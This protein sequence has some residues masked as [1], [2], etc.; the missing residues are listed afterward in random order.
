MLK[1][2]NVTKKY[3]KTTALDDVSMELSEGECVLLL[4]ANGAGKTT[5]LQWIMGNI[6]AESGRFDWSDGTQQVGYV[7]QDASLM[8][9]VTI[10]EL[11][12]FT[13]KMYPDPLSY[14]EVLQLS[15]LTE[16][17]KVKTDHLSIGQKRKLIFALALVGR[18]KLLIMDE[19]TAGMDVSARKHVYE[20][21]RQLKQQGM[22]ILMTTHLLQEASL[23][24]DRVLFMEKGRL[25]SDQT[26]SDIEQTHSWIRFDLSGS[27]PRDLLEGA[28]FQRNGLTLRWE[29][30][31]DRSDE[32]ITWLVR[33]AVPFR[34]LTVE[35]HTVEH[36]YEELLGKEGIHNENMV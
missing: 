20:Q 3:G 9:R 17:A 34:N 18:P 29:L 12:Q 7:L 31:T 28:G 26:V 22:T 35:K 2:S 32:W 13:R 11:I 30:K 33:E 5:L 21:I 15:G 25:K 6:R 16:Q 4:G 23:L 10:K 19:P 1:L 36:F 24:G 8:D 14:E 27:T